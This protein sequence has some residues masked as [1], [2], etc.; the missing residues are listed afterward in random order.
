MSFVPFV[1]GVSILASLIAFLLVIPEDSIWRFQK[2]AE[3][4]KSLSNS[5]FSRTLASFM[6][7]PFLLP[8]PYANS[9][10]VSSARGTT[11]VSIHTTKFIASNEAIFSIP[12]DLS[13]L[14]IDGIHNIPFELSQLS[15]FPKLNEE[16]KTI[17]SIAFH[18]S[19]DL[20]RSSPLGLLWKGVGV[21][22]IPDN[23]WIKYK[24]LFTLQNATTGIDEIDDAVLRASTIVSE[25]L[26]FARSH[27]LARFFGITETEIKWSYIFLHAFG[28]L[29]PQGRKIIIAPLV[30]ARHST[31]QARTVSITE[32]ADTIDIL[33]S[34][35]SNLDRGEEILVDGK[36]YL[37]DAYA[38]LFHGSWIGDG[39]IHRGKVTLRSNN[40]SKIDYWFS[41]VEEESKMFREW[42]LGIFTSTLHDASWAEIRAIHAILNSLQMK[43]E[44]LR[45]SLSSLSSAKNGVIDCPLERIRF[46]YF[47]GI[48]TEINFFESL[49]GIK[50]SEIFDGH[51]HL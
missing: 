46:I 2:T 38:F 29:G 51:Y 17:L 33:T 16:I 30:F 43:L 10:V 9:L 14:V 48:L 50:R 34:S 26:Q 23:R 20:E 31:N 28:V 40:N 12:A 44:S 6:D 3:P 25:T 49:L 32:S 22:P 21:E 11:Q 24:G 18:K 47:N 45:P 15:G 1:G 35:L 4:I 37:S 39:S 42:L 19:N 13:G 36:P 5:L 41:N 7:N 8:T 27:N